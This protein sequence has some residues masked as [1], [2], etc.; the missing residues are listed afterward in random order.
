MG[1]AQDEAVA[2]VIRMQ[3]SVG[4]RAATDGELRRKSWHMDFI[5]QLS[6]VSRTQD[7]GQSYAFR[8]ASGEKV[9]SAQG[10]IRVDGKVSLQNTI[11]G[12]AFAYL[13]DTVT[14]APCVRLVVASK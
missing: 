8:K 7:E 14:T 9:V 11:F 10:A 4:L 2:S 3:E 12:D 13:R 6:G 5:Y 1:R